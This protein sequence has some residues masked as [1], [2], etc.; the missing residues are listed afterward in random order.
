VV[1]VTGNSRHSVAASKFNC[2]LAFP[3]A[4]RDEIHNYF[5]MCCPF[6]DKLIA[7][8]LLLERRNKIKQLV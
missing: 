3:G 6:S 4:L 7:F 8:N 5:F 1:F 2:E